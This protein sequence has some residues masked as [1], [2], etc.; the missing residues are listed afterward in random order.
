VV[1]PHSTAS[2]RWERDALDAVE[3]HM[4]SQRISIL[5]RRSV[6]ADRANLTGRSRSSRFFV[7]VPLVDA[8]H[9]PCSLRRDMPQV[10]CNTPIAGAR[11]VSCRVGRSL[12]WALVSALLLSSPIAAAD[13]EPDSEPAPEAP[14]TQPGDKV[15][16]VRPRPPADP[17]VPVT[18]DPKERELTA[19]DVANA[20]LPGDES[21]RKDPGDRDPALSQVARGLLFFPKLA[22]DLALLPA[23]GSVWAIDRYH[24]PD[25]YNKVFFNDEMTIGLY[26][27][28]SID[29][30]Y[31][32]VAGARF[33]HRDLFGRKE[34]LGLQAA[35]GSRYRQIYAATLR[36]GQGLGDRF[37]IG[38]DAGYERRPND[39]FYGI[40][41]GDT[42]TFAGEPVDPLADASSVE[43][44]YRQARA[45]FGV[46]ADLRVWRQLHLRAAGVGSRVEFGPSN[47][48]APID[49]R[50]DTSR[51]PGF[52]GVEFGY[53]ELEL[54]WDGRH[55]RAPLDP[56]A[57]YSEGSLVGVFGGRMH[58]LDGGPDF[59]RYGVDLQHFFRLA[60]GPRVLAL[61]FHGEG[62]TGRRDEVPFTELP[63][64]G[65]STY[66]RG[67]DLDRF[68]DRVAALT[69]ATYSWDL[70][71]WVSANLFVDAGRVFS[72]LDH[73]SLDDLRVGYGASI[74][75]HSLK[76]FI[77]EASIAS[78]IDGGVSLNLSFNRVFDID[79][80]VRRK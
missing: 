18:P 40:G 44:R 32:I 15:S 78:S 38:V 1:L 58:R 73:L 28:I 29:S 50:Y 22:V 24:L 41:N 79:E 59:S 56:D 76:S 67:Y 2:P 62:V 36:T 35:A 14:P 53:S 5:E 63:R 17:V 60:K 77:M 69:S 70:S 26:P 34:Q 39:A 64:L 66:L 80:R 8:W 52:G 12:L 54:R 51:L 10:R 4:R 43:A 27:T 13:P 47:E 23:R 68:R 57:V 3:H 42:M 9:L 16:V 55:S 46:T 65:G 45:R 11:H 31:G 72:G 25:L 21:G 30:S 19:D 33:V 48:G 6:R 20:P 7:D 49:E 61:R 75:G 71:Q 74:E 37:E